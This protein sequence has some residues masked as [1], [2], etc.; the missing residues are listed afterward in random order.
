MA[1]TNISI[2]NGALMAIGAERISSLT[3]SSEEAAVCNERFAHVRDAVLQMFP[4]NC[5]T[6]RKTLTQDSTAP[7]YDYQYRYLLPTSPLCFSVLEVY[8]TDDWR[9]EEDYLVT[10]SSEVNILYIGKNTDPAKYP[11]YLAELISAR[12]AVDIAY[13]LTGSS[14][15]AGNAAKIYNYKMQEALELEGR[16]GNMPRTTSDVYRDT[17]FGTRR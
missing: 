17:W 16:Q 10:D 3:E 5:C 12:L 13:K 9:I 1:A 8:E 11:P 6:Y 4:W 15:V 2:C 14:E 7:I